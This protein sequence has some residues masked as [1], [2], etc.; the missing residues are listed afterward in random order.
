MSS[1]KS[2]LLGSVIAAASLAPN[3][4]A[5]Q[6][7]ESNDQKQNPTHITSEK[8]EYYKAFETMY[9]NALYLKYRTDA[10]I[11]GNAPTPKEMIERIKST[12]SEYAAKM[13]DLKKNHASKEEL[14]KI[15]KEQMSGVTISDNGVYSYSYEK[16]GK[17][18]L[19]QGELHG[20]A[21][22]FLE[23]EKEER[24]FKFFDAAKD[25]IGGR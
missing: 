6:T 18:R 1:K 11:K 22:S 16:D 7:V 9:S 10:G 23:I 8:S 19:A 5:A 13:L 3:N 14:K 12:S 20:S 15:H 17:R 21:T 24:E 25:K 2:L 4:A